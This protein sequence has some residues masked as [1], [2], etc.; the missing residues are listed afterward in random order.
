MSARTLVLIFGVALAGCDGALIGGEC[1]EGYANVDGGCVRDDATGGGGGRGDVGGADAGVG[2]DGHRGY[3]PIDAL[4]DR[5]RRGSG[6][7]SPIEPLES[8]G[9]VVALGLDV[10][11]GE[12]ARA[13]LTNAALLTVHDPVRI[14]TLGTFES[15]SYDAHVES[16][17]EMGVYGRGRAASFARTS[18][19]APASAPLT[20]LSDVVVVS[21]R[22]LG[23]RRS[24][25]PGWR[26][27]LGAFAAHGGIVIV[28]ANSRAAVGAASFL[29]ETELLSGAGAEAQDGGD[30]V[31]DT[32]TDALAIGITSPLDVRGP[33]VG[34]TLPDA[35]DAVTVASA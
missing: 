5:G 24:F 8:A 32:W 13:M 10:D 9:H 6:G 29:S 12:T 4:G 23:R 18:L 7:A 35:A 11:S 28:L 30:I 21:S 20:G 2:G 25:D 15:A 19:D 33:V 14:L 26:D 16:V 22:A 34:F 27:A 3:V 31:V 1:L 17:I